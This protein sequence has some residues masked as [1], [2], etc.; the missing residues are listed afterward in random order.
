MQINESNNEKVVF[1]RTSMWAYST[2]EQSEI[3][4]TAT[5]ENYEMMEHAVKYL[6]EKMDMGY[7]EAM[8]Y[9]VKGSSL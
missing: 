2:S 5:S 9:V 4:R 3:L 1:N 7:S 8:K 6:V